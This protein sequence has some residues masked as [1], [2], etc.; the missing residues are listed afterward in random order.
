MNY[1]YDKFGNEIT[2]IYPS[3]LPEIDLVNLDDSP[4]PDFTYGLLYTEQRYLELIEQGLKPQQ[5]RQILP[6]AC[7]TELVMT[8]FVSDWYKLFE[9]R[10]GKGADPDIKELII[11]LRDEFNRRFGKVK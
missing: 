4:Y 3:W 2:F 5:A 11:P 9:L 1:S 7:K 10:C 6:N 8:G